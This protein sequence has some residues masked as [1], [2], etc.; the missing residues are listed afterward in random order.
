LA[1]GY[2]L[3]GKDQESAC[4]LS[5]GFLAAFVVSTYTAPGWL[6]C[7]IG[8]IGG[9]PFRHPNFHKNQKLI[10]KN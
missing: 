3:V 6:V 10:L 8:L 5:A 7:G 4:S 9:Y 2:I 1:G